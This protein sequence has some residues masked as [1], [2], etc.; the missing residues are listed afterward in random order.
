MSSAPSRK[1]KVVSK[2]THSCQLCLPSDNTLLF[3]LCN[4]SSR[5]TSAHHCSIRVDHGKTTWHRSGGVVMSRC[6]PHGRL[7]PRP[8][9]ISV[10]GARPV[11]VICIGI[12]PVSLLSLGDCAAQQRRHDQPGWWSWPARSGRRW[13]SETQ[14]FLRQLAKVKTR[15]VPRGWRGC[16]GGARFSRAPVHGLLHSLSWKGEVFWDK[17]DPLQRLTMSLS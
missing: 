13:S 1:Q 3:R 8:V 17:M 7:R 9:G 15:C 6:Q 10:G 11:A 12:S 16:G 14:S 2:A 5:M 4:P